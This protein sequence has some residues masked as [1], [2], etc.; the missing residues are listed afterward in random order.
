M[1]RTD[2][3]LEAHDMRRRAQN[4]EELPGV[5]TETKRRG[6]VRTTV[7]QVLDGEGERA[8][9]KA[10]GTYLSME[11]DGCSGPV[12]AAAARQLAGHLR[13]L[14]PSEGPVMVV[15]LGNRAVT[16]DA[17]G[18]LTAGELLI[19]AHLC[20]R[21]P[22]FRPVSAL[23][24]GVRGQTGLESLEIVRAVAARVEP[25]CLI[26]VDALAA[27]EFGHIGTVIQ[28]TDTGIQP[29]SGVGNRGARLDRAVMGVPVLAMGVPT[30]TDLDEAG[31]GR[32]V[33][34]ADIDLTVASMAK[35]LG[36]AVNQALHP[37]L[38]KAELDGFLM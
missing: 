20:G 21:F 11:L 22:F 7:V 19:T 30:V 32:I 36:E 1:K 13:K 25:A 5:R 33:T 17:L 2:L 15:G 14:V 37:G 16:P 27:A 28:L 34:T 29:G 23:C 6:P 4:N 38:S 3:A 31:Q 9:G 12:R 26:A 35:L 18:A 10:R 8:M 24:P